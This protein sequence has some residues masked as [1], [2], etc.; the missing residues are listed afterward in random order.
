MKIVDDHGKPFGIILFPCLKKVKLSSINVRRVGQGAPC[1]SSTSFVKYGASSFLPV[2][3][4][5]L[6]SRC[7]NIAGWT[8]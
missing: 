8:G 1:K 3:V 6:Y 7:P 5:K 2:T 4:P